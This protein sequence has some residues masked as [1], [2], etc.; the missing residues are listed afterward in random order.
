MIQHFYDGDYG[1]K[2][3]AYNGSYN[4]LIVRRRPF[5]LVF[6]QKTL[7]WMKFNK[8]Y[9]FVAYHWNVVI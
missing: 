2:G 7:F 4:E 5:F 8:F 1:K 6:Q 3:N 9:Y